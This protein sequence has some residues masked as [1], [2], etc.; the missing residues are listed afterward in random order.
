MFRGP[1]PLSPRPFRPALLNS[2]EEPTPGPA[3]HIPARVSF[4]APMALAGI[5]S[6]NPEGM[7]LNTSGPKRSTWVRFSKS[8]EIDFNA[9]ATSR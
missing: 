2:D 7:L 5:E 4:I 6:R 9:S 3:A 1:K 8:L